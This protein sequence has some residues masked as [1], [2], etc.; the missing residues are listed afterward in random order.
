MAFGRELD[1][2][3]IQ[4]LPC[5]IGFRWIIGRSLEVRTKSI[6][7]RCIVGE[8]RFGTPDGA[9]PSLALNEPK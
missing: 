4:H 8:S 1:L 5:S 7:C 9:K 2:F 6:L 3:C